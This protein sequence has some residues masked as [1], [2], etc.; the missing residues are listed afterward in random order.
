MNY[1]D[2]FNVILD[3]NGLL[4]T[5]LLERLSIPAKILDQTVLFLDYYIQDDDTSPEI[6]ADKLYDDI[7]LHWLILLSNSMNDPFFDWPLTTSKFELWVADKYDAEL[8][9][10]RH[11][12]NEDG[13]IVNQTAPGAVSVSNYQ[14]E[15]E[16][17]EK[18]RT[19]KLVH[20][21]YVSIVINNINVAFT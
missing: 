18:R 10:I 16:E 4:L 21:D 5:N 14:Y 9:D 15:L 20:P 19:I 2:K 17:N 7:S 6:V 1:F 3:N 13:Y 12:V 8:M 11:Y